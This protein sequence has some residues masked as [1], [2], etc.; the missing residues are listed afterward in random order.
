MLAGSVL[1]RVCQV[2]GRLSDYL[3]VT[4]EDDANLDLSSF[5]VSTHAGLLLDG[6]GDAEL[7]HRNREILQGRA[8]EGRGGRSATTM[9]S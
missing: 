7:L 9:Y 8:K 3:E 6:V 2:L 4:V 5:D 1:K